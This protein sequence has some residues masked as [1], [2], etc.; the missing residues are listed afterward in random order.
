MSSTIWPLFSVETEQ[1]PVGVAVPLKVQVSPPPV[2]PTPTR[3]PPVDAE[4][5]VGRAVVSLKL[6]VP[7]A[8]LANK[9]PFEPAV[10]VQ[11]VAVPP[12]PVWHG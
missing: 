7:L 6:P 2:T 9:L 1:V 11:V 4:V 3:P 12:V 5:L 8:K 10:I